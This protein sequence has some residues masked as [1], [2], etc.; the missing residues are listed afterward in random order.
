MTVVYINKAFLLD[1][2]EENNCNLVGITS[3]QFL[4]RRFQSVE[5]HTVQV[6]RDR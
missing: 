6:H 4:V 5:T 3:L 2:Q 1:E